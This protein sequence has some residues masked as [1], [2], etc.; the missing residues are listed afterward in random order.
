M[1]M[2]KAIG[3]NVTYGNVAPIILIMTDYISVTDLGSTE[4]NVGGV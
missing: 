1:I 2:M 4:H 3:T